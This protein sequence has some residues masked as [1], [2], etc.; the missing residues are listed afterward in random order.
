MSDFFLYIDTYISQMEA[1][2]EITMTR[3]H[4]YWHK[5]R[6]NAYTVDY[7]FWDTCTNALLCGY[8]FSIGA[9]LAGAWS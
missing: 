9:Q 3:N 1:A 8:C 6:Q 7:S 2:K 4:N 5:S